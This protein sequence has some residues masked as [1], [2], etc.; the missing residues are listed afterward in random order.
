MRAM[1]AF[2]QKRLEARRESIST[3]EAASVTVMNGQVQ[4]GSMQS[5]RS[6]NQNKLRRKPLQSR[7]RRPE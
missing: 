2:A 5:L 7:E 3:G 1:L 4:V 6:L